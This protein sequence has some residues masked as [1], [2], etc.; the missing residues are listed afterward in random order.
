[1][2]VTTYLAIT[3]AEFAEEECEQFVPLLIACYFCASKLR[4]L[5]PPSLKEN[6]GM[7]TMPRV[8]FK[9]RLVTIWATAA[10]QLC[11][12]SKEVELRVSFSATRER[13]KKWEGQTPKRESCFFV[14]P[15]V[16]SLIV[17]AE[18]S[19]S[20]KKLFVD[21]SLAGNMTFRRVS[22]QRQRWPCWLANLEASWLEAI[23][24]TVCPN[25]QVLTV[26]IAN[27]CTRFYCCEMFWQV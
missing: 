20:A 2:F 26:W 8:N 14:M 12:T 17:S 19:S 9:Q 4:W 23:C 5:G 21:T 10:Q 18:R 7:E 11:R 27:Q 15:D 13:Y 22:A 1:M 16:L 6:A 25:C 24:L 3:I